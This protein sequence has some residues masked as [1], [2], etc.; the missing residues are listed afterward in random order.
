[1]IAEEWAGKADDI[2]YRRTKCALH[3]SPAERAAF[4]DWFATAR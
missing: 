2:L 1:M 4:V 3:M